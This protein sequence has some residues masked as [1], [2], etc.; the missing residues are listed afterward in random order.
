MAQAI[1]KDNTI[2]RFASTEKALFDFAQKA[3]KNTTTPKG[4]SAFALKSTNT[5][6]IKKEE[7]IV[8][9]VL[10]I[11]KP[12]IKHQITQP[13]TTEETVPKQTSNTPA[14]K[15]QIVPKQ[16]TITSKQNLI[17]TPKNNSLTP[18]IGAGPKQ[19]ITLKP[20]TK[21]PSEINPVPLLNVN[22][23]RQA[24]SNAEKN[25]SPNSSKPA[26]KINSA[27]GIL[28]DIE[29]EIIEEEKLKKLKE[30][31]EKKSKDSN[32]NILKSKEEEEDKKKKT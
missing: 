2:T 4:P 10:T 7:E 20:I 13:V 1:Q 31:E 16:N 23:V 19:E 8:T 21:K 3:D 9:T 14:T 32:N 12:E 27:R 30:E 22:S 24:I 6:I 15:S 25:I 29:R 18:K 28:K 26:I 5:P 11:K 17:S